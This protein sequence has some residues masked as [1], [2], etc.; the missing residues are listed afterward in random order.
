MGPSTRRWQHSSTAISCLSGC[1]L[2]WFI[3]I[4]EQNA[5]T[6][7]AAPKFRS[8]IFEPKMVTEPSTFNKT[9]A[10]SL[11]AL[12]LEFSAQWSNIHKSPGEKGQAEQAIS[13]FCAV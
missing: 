8:A 13:W 6:P 11:Q 5:L 7:S 4:E 9:A 1:V 3:Q 10:A 12:R 2:Y